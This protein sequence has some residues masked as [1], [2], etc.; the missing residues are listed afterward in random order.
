MQTV[1]FAAVLS[2]LPKYNVLWFGDFYEF[3]LLAVFYESLSLISRFCSPSE[4]IWKL[5]LQSEKF[6]HVPANSHSVL[7]HISTG[8]N[9]QH[10]TAAR[11]IYS[12]NTVGILKVVLKEY[13]VIESN[14]KDLKA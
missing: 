2:C 3:L 8:H 5:S 14:S 9:R 4:H 12:V 1:I 7:I 10:R 11:Y 13:L 6:R